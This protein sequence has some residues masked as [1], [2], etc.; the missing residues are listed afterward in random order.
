MFPVRRRDFLGWVGASLTT[1]LGCAS[2]RP[3]AVDFSDA[4]RSYQP[5]DFDRVRDLWT[6]H[7]KLVRDVGTV[8][9][10]WATYKSSDFRQAYIEQYAAL[11]GLGADEKRELRT[12]QLEAARTSYEFHLVA[13]S[14]EWTW[15]N[16]EHKDT[17]WRLALGDRAGNEISPN[18][19]S[20]E[21]LPELYE[22]RFFPL[23]TDFSR[24]YAVRFP[25]DPAGKFAGPQTGQLTLKVAGPL[26]TA[27]VA[28]ESASVRG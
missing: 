20:H 24:T 25:R 13:Q 9:E 8:I 5:G 28:W 18:H 21:K 10:I 7:A 22:L 26:G 4:V 11:Y 14:T 12:A 15:N 16:L 2:R 23:R 27:S 1:G 6:R 19:V 17:V 3:P